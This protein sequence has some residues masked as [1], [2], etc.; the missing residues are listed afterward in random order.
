METEFYAPW[1]VFDYSPSHLGTF[2]HCPS[3]SMHTSGQVNPREAPLGTGS[4]KEWHQ[5]VLEPVAPQVGL[6][7]WISSCPAP[8]IN[9]T[10]LSPLNRLVILVKKSQLAMDVQVNF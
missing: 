9:E 3:N 7:M 8:F 5:G 2:L 1:L 6:P 10:I 4:C